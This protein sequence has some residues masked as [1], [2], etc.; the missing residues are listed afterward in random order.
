M[1]SNLV[2]DAK[3]L[4]IRAKIIVSKDDPLSKIEE[5][6]KL[7]SLFAKRK[8]S[9]ENMNLNAAKLLRWKKHHAD[10]FHLSRT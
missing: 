9:L 3:D 5:S 7:L 4:Q 6:E 2:S 8:A 10:T 1:D